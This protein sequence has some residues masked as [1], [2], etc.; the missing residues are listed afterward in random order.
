MSN[1]TNGSIEYLSPSDGGSSSDIKSYGELYLFIPSKKF[2]K[3]RLFKTRSNTAPLKCII[4]RKCLVVITESVDGWHYIL[5]NELEG[6]CRMGNAAFSPNGGILTNLTFYR[7]YMEWGGNNSFFCDGRIMVGSDFN[8]FLF[9]NFLFITPSALFFVF[10]IPDMDFSILFGVLMLLIFLYC[11]I[12]LWTCALT[13]PGIIPRNL[14]DISP[15]LPPGEST[16]IYG[17]KMCDTCNIYRP[18]R[19]KHC[20]SCDNCVELFDH[21]CPWVGSCVGKRNYRYFLH[22]VTSL[23]I[24]T[25][26]AFSISLYTL[27]KVAKESDRIDSDDTWLMKVILSITYVPFPAAIAIFSLLALLSIQSLCSYHLFLVWRGQTTNEHIRG[28]YRGRENIHDKGCCLNLHAICC[29]PHPPSLLLNQADEVSSSEYIH[30]AIHISHIFEERSVKES[31][32]N[33]S[34]DSSFYSQSFD[35]RL[36]QS[37]P[38]SDGKTLYSSSDNSDRN[39]ISGEVYNMLNKGRSTGDNSDRISISNLSI[40]SV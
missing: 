9:T 31:V 1:T 26:A 14:A 8:F 35:S 4:R 22:F 2:P 10:V 11:V 21:H 40:T 13:E 27:I 5:C 24:F 20:A 3:L 6:W 28:V 34:I 39:T 38:Q 7:R 18:P 37:R 32:G 25:I 36:I 15:T 16:G 19:S 29:T 12:S 33:P 23:S 30:R 17:Y